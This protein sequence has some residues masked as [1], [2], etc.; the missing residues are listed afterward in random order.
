[1]TIPPS[2]P[3]AV[4]PWTPPA[5]LDRCRPR[6]VRL[7][8]RGRALIV[9]ALLFFAGGAAAFVV[10]QRVAAGQL[11]QQR[12]FRE[13]A[14]SATG[15]V[16][17]LGRERRMTYGFEAHGR[18]YTRTVTLRPKDR[19][20]LKVGDPIALRY[21]PSD[22]KVNEIG[23]RL[24]RALPPAIPYVAGLGL[25]LVGAAV[26]IPLRRERH[27]L[28]EGR[29]ARATVTRHRKSQHGTEYTFAFRT[30]SGARHTGKSGLTRRPPDV[31]ATITVL[32]DPD[33]PRRSAPY[34]LALVAPLY[35]A[36]LRPR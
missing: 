2:S 23:D 13:H 7:T 24:P 6:E 11:R 21:L 18:T 3:T 10:L 17:R 35:T 32:Y 26:L 16:A 14:V 12:A 22:P 5:G 8:P 27:L 28:S 33:Q 25:A 36:R 30:L 20:A 34:P 1:M 29:P 19:A 15:T 4:G 9:L 31:D